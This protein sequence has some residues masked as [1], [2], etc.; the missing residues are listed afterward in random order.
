MLVAIYHMIRDDSDFCPVDHDKVIKNTKKTTELELN[1]IIAFLKAQGADDNTIRLIEAQ[2][3]Q[4]G[5]AKTESGNEKASL[6]KEKQSRSDGTGIQET[7]N[8]INN[9][10]PASQQGHALNHQKAPVIRSATA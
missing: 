3:S 2:C 1:N 9:R 10:K 7:A 5:T 8:G 4:N 6:K